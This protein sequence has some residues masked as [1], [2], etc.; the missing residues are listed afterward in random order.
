[1]VGGN[2]V[3]VCIY[4]YLLEEVEDASLE[5]FIAETTRYQ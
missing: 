4:R 1:M 5:K 2:L 3:V